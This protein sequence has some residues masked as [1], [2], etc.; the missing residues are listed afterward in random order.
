MEAVIS[1]EHRFIDEKDRVGYINKGSKSDGDVCDDTSDGG[2]QETPLK[3][4]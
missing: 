4:T 1:Y 3:W 2:D